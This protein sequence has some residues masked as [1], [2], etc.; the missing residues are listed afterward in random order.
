MKILLLMP[1]DEKWTH[2]ATEIYKHLDEET[3]ERTFC[4]PMF[5]EYLVDTRAVPNWTHALFQT[6]IAAQFVYKTAQKEK[7]DLLLIGNIGDT[8]EFD[9]VFNFQDA[10]EALPYEDLFIQ[11]TKELVREDKT[12]YK[13]IKALH[14]AAESKMA[15]KNC[16]ATAEFLSAYIKTD[17]KAKEKHQEIKEKYNGRNS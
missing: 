8:Y 13:Y 15:L 2:M 6:M 9:V 3:K 7:D 10:K 16:E 14:T 1:C 5:A 11:K 4:M 17:F 12:L